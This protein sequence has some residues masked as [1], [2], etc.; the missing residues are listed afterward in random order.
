MYYLDQELPGEIA[1]VRIRNGSAY[2]I[3]QKSEI[4]VL[5][6]G[7]VYPPELHL[8]S[9]IKRIKNEDLEIVYQK[10]QNKIAKLENDIYKKLLPYKGRGKLLIRAEMVQSIDYQKWRFTEKIH[11]IKGNLR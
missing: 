9:E 10:A 3:T 1:L 6:G 7:I 5:N 11:V 4:I 8:Y 2:S